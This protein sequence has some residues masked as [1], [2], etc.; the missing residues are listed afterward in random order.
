[1]NPIRTARTA[2][3]IQKELSELLLADTRL[4]R[5]V[6]ISA[7]E[8]RLAPDLSSARCYLSIFPD[9][10]GPE[11]LKTLQ[12]N[13]STIRYDLGNSLAS[14]MR[15]IP[16]LYFYLDRSEEYA[17]KIDELLDAN[18]THDY[19]RDEEAEGWISSLYE[20]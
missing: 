17:R 1:M 13:T 8:V 3:M 5:G 2:R 20:E 14:R 19:T 15:V 11:I 6:I 16:E 18:P 12:S 9:A 4:T 7:T 10:K